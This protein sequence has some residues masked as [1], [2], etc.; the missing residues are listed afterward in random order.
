MPLQLEELIKAYDKNKN[1]FLNDRPL[2]EERE[3]LRQ[4]FVSRFPKNKI[5]EMRIGEYV[6]GKVDAN[7][8]GANKH[9]FCY[10]H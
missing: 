4:D 1:L 3:K 6:Q 5:I 7:T 2:L 8:G 9:A 10:G